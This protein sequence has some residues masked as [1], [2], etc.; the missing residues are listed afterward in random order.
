[1]GGSIGASLISL[2]SWMPKKSCLTESN[3]QH[4][5]FLWVLLMRSTWTIQSYRI[6]IK[7]LLQHTSWL[8]V[9]LKTKC[10]HFHITISSIYSYSLRHFA[11][12]SGFLLWEITIRQYVGQAC[13][14]VGTAQTS[15]SHPSIMHSTLPLD[16]ESKHGLSCCLSFIYACL[17]I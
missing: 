13:W 7:T 2:V 1:M 14:G 16:L 8:W 3:L 10:E 6:I 12:K 4:R 5:S 17:S 15:L 9:I 11:T